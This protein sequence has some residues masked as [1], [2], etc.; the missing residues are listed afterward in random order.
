MPQ[1]KPPLDSPNRIDA[2]ES[3]ARIPHSR[4][5]QLVSLAHMELLNWRWSWRA[6]VT[7][8][9]IGPMIFIVLMGFFA[10]DE[11]ADKLA[12]V[13]SGNVIMTLMF[14]NMNRMTSRFAFMRA[15]GTLDYYATLPVQRYLVVIATL[16]TF[17][18]LSL[19]AIVVTILF[20]SFFLQLPVHLHPTLLLVVPLAALS[21]A[22]LGAYIGV[23]S[24]TLEESST[25]SQII[26]FLFMILGPVLIPPQNLPAI[27]R[28]A[29]WFSPA[30][31]GASALRQT[32]LGPVT[33][34]LLMDLL[35]LLA[36]TIGFMLL[37]DRKMDW[38]ER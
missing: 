15:V 24:R 20:G 28:I 2:N 27:M 21:L 8:G 35:A 34:R 38:R 22:G 11:G 10:G 25:Y 17:F 31:Y 18:L 23:A 13:L 9:I 36:F 1:T 12:Y 29:G 5:E 16:I 3:T 33:P 7:T 6:T 4:F 32:L 26:L 14:T 30:T 19:P 37:V